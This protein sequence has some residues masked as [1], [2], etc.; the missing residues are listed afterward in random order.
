MAIPA[1]WSNCAKAFILKYFSVHRLVIP[2]SDW[3]NK[4]FHRLPLDSP[5]H[6]PLTL[7]EPIKELNDQ[8]LQ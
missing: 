2:Y 5:G 6:Y 8:N 4:R 1:F 3:K 7:G